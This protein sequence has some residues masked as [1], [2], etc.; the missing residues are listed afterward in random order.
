MKLLKSLATVALLQA[1]LLLPAHAGENLATIKSAGVFKIGTEGTYAPF[2]YHNES[3]KLVG[4]DVEI[5]E[6]IAAKLGVKAEFVEGKW[7]GLIAG[8][9]A[10]RYDTVINQVGITETRKQKYDFSDPYIASKA[11]LI[12]R[13]DDNNIKDFADLKG[14]KSAQSLSSNFGKLAE[15]SGAELVGTDGFDQSIQL[16]LTRRADATINDSLSFLDFKKHKPDAPVKVVAQQSDADYSGVIIRKQEPELLTAINKALADI[17]A[18]GTYQK[19]S[20]KYFGQ[21]VSK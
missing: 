4:F 18:D 20:E 17:K 10:K 21:D 15:K 13:S 1:A 6:A 11:V 14:K 12:V 2:T 7:D 16:V 8:L 5:G 3:G 9:D 19:I